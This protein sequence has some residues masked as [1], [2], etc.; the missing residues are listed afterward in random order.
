MPLLTHHPAVTFSLSPVLLR[1]R[2]Y[3]V[4]AISSP[5]FFCSRLSHRLLTLTV[6]WLNYI[7]VSPW[8]QFS[9]KN[10]PLIREK[11]FAD[12]V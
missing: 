7:L 9:E 2:N 4:A 3:S 10:E 11:N 6:A 1:N 12:N 8:S 5:F